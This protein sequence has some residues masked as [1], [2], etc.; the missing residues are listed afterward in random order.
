MVERIPWVF[1]AWKAFGGQGTDWLTYP[2]WNP[3]GS[4]KPESDRRWW[5]PPT[6][7][8]GPG[9]NLEVLVFLWHSQCL[10]YGGPG[11]AN[12]HCEWWTPFNLISFMY[13]HPVAGQ[14][15][16]IWPVLLSNFSRHPETGH[17]F[18]IAL[19]CNEQIIFIIF[20]HSTLVPVIICTQ[21]SCDCEQ[22]FAYSIPGVTR[23]SFSW[24]S[25]GLWSSLK[26]LGKF[27]LYMLIQMVAL[28][29]K[30][31][32]TEWHQSYPC[33]RCAVLLSHNWNLHILPTNFNILTDLSD[34]D[35]QA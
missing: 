12:T 24:Q 10:C 13:H 11:S 34:F 6:S 21:T 7:G 9:S 19:V 16:A 22:C 15:C 35:Q 32:P 29:Q 1:L 25:Q 18:F 23:W 26:G 2:V 14:C 8:G 5:S 20:A 33:S 3:A 27:N 28:L 30:T 4:E 31:M 17:P